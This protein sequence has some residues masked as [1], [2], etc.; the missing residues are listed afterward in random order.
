MLC[1]DEYLGK[2]VCITCVHFHCI[3][4]NDVAQLAV[5]RH[6]LHLIFCMLCVAHAVIYLPRIVNYYLI[7]LICAFSGESHPRYFSAK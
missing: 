2:C 5:G 4:Y 3:F 7:L 1:Y 6:I